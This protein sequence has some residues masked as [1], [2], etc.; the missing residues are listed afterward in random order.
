MTYEC[1]HPIFKL[2]FVSNIIPDVHIR[3]RKNM[4][5][6]STSAVEEIE[7]DVDIHFEH[8]QRTIFINQQ[9]PYLSTIQNNNE[10]TME[11]KCNTNIFVSNRKMG[12]DHNVGKENKDVGGE[13]RQ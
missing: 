2:T 7:P 9:Q 12:G 10:I 4:N 8:F 6:M 13:T 3:F 1:G 11:Y 5:Q